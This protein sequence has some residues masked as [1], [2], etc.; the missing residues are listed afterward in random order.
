[1]QAYAI[2]PYDE[3]SEIPIPDGQQTQKKRD[4]LRPRFAMPKPALVA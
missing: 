2:H 4:D 1:M 3:R